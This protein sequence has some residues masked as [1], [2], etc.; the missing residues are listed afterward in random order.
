MPRAQRLRGRIVYDDGPAG[1]Y[2]IERIIPDSIPAPVVEAS[3][4]VGP[5]GRGVDLNNVFTVNGMG[6]LCTAI[7]WSMQ[8]T[9]DNGLIRVPVKQR[10][11]YNAAAEC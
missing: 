3:A 5:L 9:T 4:G 11:A 8:Y 7:E 10:R 1:G 2:T 6:P